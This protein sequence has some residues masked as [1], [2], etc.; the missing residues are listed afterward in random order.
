MN[1]IQDVNILRPLIYLAANDLKLPTEILI[2]S[3]L[4]Q[5]DSDKLW[6][7]E[8]LQIAYQTKSLNFIIDSPLDF[9]KLV[10]NKSGIIFAGSESSV[11]NHKATHDFFKITP[12]SFITVTLQHGF[13]C[14]GFKHNEG[15][16][17]AHGKKVTFSA[18]VLCG[19]QPKALMT[20]LHPEEIDKYYHTGPTF[21]LQNQ[22]HQN[23]DI[24]QDMPGLICENLHSVRLSAN[25]DKKLEFIEIFKYFSKKMNQ[26]KKNLVL[27][28]HPAGQFLSNHKI[29]LTKNVTLD[30]KPIYKINLSQFSYGISAPSSMIIDMV[31][32]KIPVAIWQDKNKKMDTNHYHGLSTISTLEDWFH[33]SHDAIT[34][35]HYYLSIQQKFIERNYLDIKPEVIHQNY[36]HLMMQAPCYKKPLTKDNKLKILFI[37]NALIP[38]LQLCLL[39]PLESLIEKKKIDYHII[40]DTDYAKHKNQGITLNQTLID[41]KPNLIVFCRYSGMLAQN[42]LYWSKQHKV[43][44]LFHIDDDLLNIP[45]DLGQKKYEF[46]HQPQRIFTVNQLINECTLVYAANENL[47]KHFEKTNPKARIIAGEISCSGRILKKPTLKPVSVIGYMGFDHDH[48]FKV[49]LKAI[50]TYLKENKHVRFELFGKIKKPRCLNRFKDRVIVLPPVKNYDEFLQTLLERQWDIGIAPLANL[51]FNQYKSINKWLE[52]TLT[53]TAFI[54]SKNTIYDDCTSN[55]C[56]LLAFDSRS[57]L[58]ALNLFSNNPTLRVAHVLN[59]QEKVKTRYCRQ[60]HQQQLLSIFNSLT[61]SINPLSNGD[62]HKS[63]HTAAT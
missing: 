24:S 3:K 55:D 14:V 15:H 47:K 8:L 39:K 13:E 50:T 4:I 44:S 35:R 49:C 29:K 60:K 45:I 9:M 57:W 5:R 21:L 25:G 12:D 17:K 19:W 34:N 23:K 27:R 58:N 6:Q 48:D 26:E 61:K 43:P 54:G 59:A 2:T 22:F 46:H 1:L 11:K 20:S 53:G 10:Q 33:F 62:G 52:Y 16:D 42:I 41:F 30:N 31:L 18:N 32:A 63:C 38:T 36:A 37:A 7:K 51:S 56:G 40:T 28:P